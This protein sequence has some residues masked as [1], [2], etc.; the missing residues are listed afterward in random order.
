[1]KRPGL[2]RECLAA[3]AGVTILFAAL[4]L[5]LWLTA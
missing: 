2:I 1:M 4:W 3:A 5:G